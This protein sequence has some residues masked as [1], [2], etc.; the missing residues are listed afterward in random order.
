MAEN[1]EKHAF[2]TSLPG[3]LTGAAAIITAL[4]GLV[5]AMLYNGD[6]PTKDTSEKTQS[7]RAATSITS[8]PSSPVASAVKQP[9]ITPPP[10]DWPLIAEETFTMPSTAWFQGKLSDEGFKRSEVSI[11][12]GKYRWDIELH[13][14]WERVVES[15]HGPAV[16]F[17]LATD[18]RFVAFR[19]DQEFSASLLFGRASN[20]DYTF[21]I[22]SNKY[23]SLMKFD[24]T[25]NTTIISWTPINIQPQESTRLAVAVDDKHIKL[26]INGKLVGT[27]QDPAFSGGKVGMGV[28]G[29]IAGSS[30]VVDFDNFEYR[31]KP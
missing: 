8:A 12:S 5:I 21:R 31:Q 1:T 28:S 15:P 17:Y 6:K 2:W 19:P 30:G 4:T 26:Y 27:Y 22:S 25:A 14:A 24:G 10:N 18:V 3:V 20:R 16:N 9:G 11:T 13:K 23:F 29:Y 7:S